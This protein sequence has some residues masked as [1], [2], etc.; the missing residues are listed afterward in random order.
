MPSN[1]E[2]INTCIRTWINGS[3]G[4]ALNKIIIANQN[5]KLPTPPFV[6]LIL[7]NEI[8]RIGYADFAEGTERKYYSVFRMVVSI[9]LIGLTPLTHSIPQF[10]NAL[11]KYYYLFRNNNLGVIR[12]EITVTNVP[13]YFEAENEITKYVVDIPVTFVE[14]ESTTRSVGLDLEF[15]TTIKVSDTVPE[16][17]IIE[18][19]L[20]YSGTIGISE[21][22]V[23]EIVSDIN[24]PTSPPYTGLTAPIIELSNITAEGVTITCT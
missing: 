1:I 19:D 20:R 8:Q 23:V 17:P 13:N 11:E 22:P 2:N 18:G 9:E 6:F 15:R 7:D 5:K 10:I 3:L 12:D 24:S 4:I 14:V 21:F 16:L